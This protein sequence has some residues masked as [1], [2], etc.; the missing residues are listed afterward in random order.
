[1]ENRYFV[2]IVADS[3]EAM[4][5]LRDYDLDLFRQTSRVTERQRYTIDGLLAAEE[6][7]QLVQDG[8]SV[9]MQKQAM[10]KTTAQTEIVS[11]EEWL[12]MVEKE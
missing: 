2:T 10:P 1:M 4:L 12:E 11:F 5:K 6:V 7:E 8:Y 3:R 9:N